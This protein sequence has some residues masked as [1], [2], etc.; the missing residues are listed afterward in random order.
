MKKITIL[1]AGLL[2][3]FSS[4]F[5]QTWSLDKAHSNVGFGIGY[6][7]I[8]EVTG[9]FAATDAKVK[10]T[11][12]DFSDAIVE[13]T[14]DVNSLTTYVEQR[15]NHLKSPDFFDAA[16]FGTIAFKSTGIKKVKDKTYQLSGDLTFHGVTKP[17][18]LD[19]VYNGTTQNPQSKKTIAGFKVT[20][21]VNRADF[22]FA[23]AF[24]APMLGAAAKL[25][26]NIILVA[27]N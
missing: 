15:D 27:E 18:V 6:L 22:N 16:Q 10:A 1:S 3:A 7:G 21:D 23:S 14:A 9:A 5:A 19:M 26:A 24:P 13:F 11:K 20:G 8:S 17:V 12:P 4:S 25:N 2:M